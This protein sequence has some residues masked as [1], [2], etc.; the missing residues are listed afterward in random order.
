MTPSMPE[1]TKQDEGLQRIALTDRQWNRQ[2]VRFDAGSP[3][4]EVTGGDGFEKEHLFSGELAKNCL[5]AGMWEVLLFLK[6]GSGKT[7]YYQGWFTFP[8]GQ[9]RR[10]WE[11]QTGLPYWRHWYYLEHWADPAG[12]VVPM[13][14]LRRVSAEWEPPT[15][16]DP[17]ER[18][19]AAGE[20]TRKRRT[21]MARNVVHWRDIYDGHPI[22]FAAF[23]PPGRY[24]VSHPRDTQYWRLAHF[25]K[26]ILRTIVSPAVD[27]SLTELELVFNSGK[28]DGICRFFVSGFDLNALPQL[29]RMDYPKGM[30]MPMGIGVP[31]F[32][33][34]YE[35]LL[36]KDPRK[37]PYVSVLLDAQDRW[38]D[39]HSVGIDGPVLY[40]DDQDPMVLHVLLL[41]YERHSLVGHFVISTQTEQKG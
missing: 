26:A 16:F 32:N 38:I 13:A 1:W 27:S 6:E 10:L 17:A 9:Y 7:M 15:K 11:Q 22:Q 25:E 8:L 28:E 33:Q 39:H 18:V 4:I 35:D 37:S 36:R 14:K 5:N 40:R 30:Y 12:T 20:Q 19:F 31:S 24:S 29:A 21:S 2:Q 23:I 41:S 3:N 34:S